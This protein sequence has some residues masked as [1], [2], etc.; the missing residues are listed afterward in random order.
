MSESIEVESSHCGM[1]NHP[2][3]VYP[4]ADRLAQAQGECSPFIALAGAVWFI[5][6]RTA[7]RATSSFCLATYFARLRG[8]PRDIKRCGW[9]VPRLAAVLATRWSTGEAARSVAIGIVPPLKHR[10][11]PGVV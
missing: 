7:K 5:R 8:P 4:V 1:G 10:Y 11:L 3:V 9:V 6:I 2:A